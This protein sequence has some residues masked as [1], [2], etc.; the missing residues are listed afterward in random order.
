MA[1]VLFLEYV[2]DGKA[3]VSIVT[4]GKVMSMAELQNVK[5]RGWDDVDVSPRGLD[6]GLY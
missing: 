4:T 5:G 1:I 3:N 2:W 6:R